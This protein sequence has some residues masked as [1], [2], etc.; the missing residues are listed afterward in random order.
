[1]EGFFTNHSLQKVA[2]LDCFRLVLNTIKE[3]TG[4]V[5]DAVDAYQMTSQALIERT[6]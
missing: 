2:P 4:H 3:L 6:E 1:M 5:S